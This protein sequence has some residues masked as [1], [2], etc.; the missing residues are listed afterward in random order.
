MTFSGLG[1]MPKRQ[2]VLVGGGWGRRLKATPTVAA[3]IAM[4][5]GREFPGRSRAKRMV[6]HNLSH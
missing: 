3:P 4:G 6:E 5:L 1:G 2:Q